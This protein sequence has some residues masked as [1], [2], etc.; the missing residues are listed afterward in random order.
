ME[1]EYTVSTTSIFSLQR[2]VYNDIFVVVFMWLLLQV[3]ITFAGKEIPKSPFKVDVEGSAGDASKVTASG[4]GLEASGVQQ[5]K[6]TY[7]EVFTEGMC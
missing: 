3:T 5:G 6:K 2:F 4:P 7:F 1:G